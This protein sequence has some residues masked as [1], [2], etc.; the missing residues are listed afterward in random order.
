M[1]QVLLALGLL[2][3]TM[4]VYYWAGNRFVPKKANISVSQ[5]K[6]I[7]LEIPEN[8]QVGMEKEIKLKAKHEKGKIVSFLLN[9][10]F[11]VDEVEIT[12]A[13]VNK[14]VFNSGIEV[15]I[16]EKLG[17]IMLKGR[18]EGEKEALVNEEVN[19]ATIKVKGMKK[20]ETTISVDK[21]PVIEVWDGEKI[22]EESFELLDFKLKF[23]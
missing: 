10:N 18:Y 8:L 1:K 4:A 15:Q 5:E 3:L 6:Q 7:L 23:L 20:G 12:S 14:E 22:T 9:L 13:E 16:D 17:K 19:L 21:T 11:K 2:L